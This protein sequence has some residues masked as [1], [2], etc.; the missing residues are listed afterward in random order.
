VTDAANVALVRSI[1][2]AHEGGDY[3]ATE[4][5]HPEIEYVIADGPSPGRWRGLAGMTGA[6]REFLSAWDE[7]RVE[8]DEYRELDDQRVLVLTHRSGRGKTSGLEVGQL[9][10]RA[11]DLFHVRDGKVTK[12]VAY[13][14]RDRALA[15][16]GL[17]E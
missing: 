6:V 12:Y 11:A 2:A 3:S 16:L 1:V 10:S 4:W 8:A 13:W 5:A 15:D 14:D 9:R 17:K 7:C